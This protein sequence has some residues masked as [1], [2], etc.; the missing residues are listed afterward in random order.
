MAYSIY[1]VNCN[2]KFHV[3][4]QKLSQ[5]PILLHKVVYSDLEQLTWKLKTKML[6]IFTT[7]IF[8]DL[9]SFILKND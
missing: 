7:S 1:I 3:I 5:F 4:Q 6:P 2:D 8:K 9:K